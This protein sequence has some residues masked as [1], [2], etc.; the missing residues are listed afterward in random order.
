MFFPIETAPFDKPVILWFDSG[1]LRYPVECV[2]AIK[3]ADYSPENWW[4]CENNEHIS[5]R[6]TARILGWSPAP[7]KEEIEKHVHQLGTGKV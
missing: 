5:V 1:Y 2:T 3:C 7:L 6:F 4:R